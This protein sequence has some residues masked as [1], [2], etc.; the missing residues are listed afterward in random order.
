MLVIQI[1]PSIDYKK[2]SLKIKLCS[3]IDEYIRS[4]KSVYRVSL[5]EGNSLLE[6]W[7]GCAMRNKADTM[8]MIREVEEDA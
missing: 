1:R 6:Y 8:M 4:K 2:S 3:F 5:R 7:D